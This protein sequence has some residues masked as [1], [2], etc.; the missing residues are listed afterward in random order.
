MMWKKQTLQAKDQLVFLA[1]KKKTGNKSVHMA[2][3]GETLYD[4]SQ[5]EGI[6]LSYLKTYNKNLSNGKLKEGTIV[7]LFKPKESKPEQS[8]KQV[9][10]KFEFHLFRNLFK[11]KKK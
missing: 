7:L 8:L 6:Q 1:Q 4:I 11:R 2:K 3:E 9:S 5:T 10:F